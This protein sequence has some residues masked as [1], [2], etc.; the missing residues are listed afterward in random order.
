MLII[1]CDFDFSTL[2]HSRI[3]PLT[4]TPTLFSSGGWHTLNSPKRF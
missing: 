1:G 3:K 4:V 2:F